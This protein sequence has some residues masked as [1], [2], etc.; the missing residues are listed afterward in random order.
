M[1]TKILLIFLFGLLLINSFY[2]IYA[3][4]PLGDVDDKIEKIESAKDKVDELG[5]QTRDERFWNEKWEYLGKEYPKLLLRSPF[6]RAI[7]SFLSRFSMVF[8]ILF[9]MDYSLSLIL[10]FVVVFWIWT[11]FTLWGIIKA[12][13][14]VGEKFNF[15]ASLLI[16][17]VLAQ[18][19]FFENLVIFLGNLVFAPQYAW[20]RFLVFIM[21]CLGFI[22]LNIGDKRLMKFLEERKEKKQRRTSAFLRL[23]NYRREKAIEES[24]RAG[25]R[26]SLF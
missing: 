22:F 5:Q 2:F 21:V 7:N 19:K 18:L 11:L 8:R 20:T 24:S 17:I 12:S 14:I 16:V 23:I 13:G 26:L 15:I 25:D 6:V 4:N 9:G 1:K 3:G 10:F